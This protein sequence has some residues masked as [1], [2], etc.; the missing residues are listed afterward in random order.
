LDEHQELFGDLL[1][2][3]AVAP[4]VTALVR[5]TA[6]HNSKSSAAALRNAG[7]E[8]ARLQ[9]PSKVCAGWEVG[10]DQLAVGRLCGHGAPR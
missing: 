9:S 8:L 2:T 10:L 1:R 4:E 6:I 3:P 5:I 7:L